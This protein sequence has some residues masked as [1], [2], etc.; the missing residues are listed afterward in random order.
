[1]STDPGHD[2]A[3][4]AGALAVTLADAGLAAAR[5]RRALRSD[6]DL[7]CLAT[8]VAQLLD[9]LVGVTITNPEER[10]REHKRRL[11]EARDRLL[12]QAVLADG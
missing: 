6:S 10:I 2:D 9:A 7:R 8:E 12:T 4:T 3:M 11:R 5:C 1:M